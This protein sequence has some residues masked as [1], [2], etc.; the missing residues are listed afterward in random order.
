MTNWSFADREQS[1]AAPTIETP[2]STAPA[3]VYAKRVCYRC[4]QILPA[5]QLHR[6]TSKVETGT[7]N[8]TYSDR[9]GR[10]TGTATTSHH[11]YRTRYYCDE[12]NGRRIQKMLLLGLIVGGLVMLVLALT[13]FDAVSQRTPA[14][15]ADAEV[16][17]VVEPSAVEPPVDPEPIE[18]SA[19][20]EAVAEPIAEPS[21]YLDG[22]TVGEMIMDA[23]CE[24]TIRGQRID[25]GTC[26]VNHQT[27]AP[28]VFV[29]RQDS[30]CSIDFSRAG[31]DMTA[32][33]YS[34]RQQCVANDG[35]EV[36][37][38]NLSYFTREGDCLTSEYARICVRRS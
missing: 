31:A 25:D 2:A 9:M 34:Y 27:A 1:N 3:K 16:A 23:P 10:R 8:R 37:D 26:T 32:T 6:V 30:G 17:E 11:S 14:P 29:N 22:F 33:L 35:A 21:T 24:I 28:S 4:E 7:S 38:M 19:P 20:V 18:S 13:I 15:M 12:C 36:D 5:N